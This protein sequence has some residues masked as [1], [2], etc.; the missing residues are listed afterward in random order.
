MLDTF[1]Y[2]SNKI[3]FRDNLKATINYKDKKNVNKVQ[4][5]SYCFE[6]FDAI[7]IFYLMIFPSYIVIS[8]ILKTELNLVL[9]FHLLI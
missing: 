7:N 9:I 2:F 6:N 3:K 1:F 8:N 5:S 4:C